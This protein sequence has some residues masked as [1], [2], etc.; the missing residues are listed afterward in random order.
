MVRLP[1]ETRAGS[2]SRCGPLGSLCDRPPGG[3][4]DHQPQHFLA[5]EFDVFGEDSQGGDVEGASVIRGLSGVAP[6]FG[7]GLGN[8]AYRYLPTVGSAFGKR[9]VIG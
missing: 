3:T 8:K 5:I 6:T 4:L 2:R 9:P 1:W 7:N